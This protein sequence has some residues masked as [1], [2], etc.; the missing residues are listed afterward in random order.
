MVSCPFAWD[1]ATTTGPTGIVG[2]ATTLIHALNDSGWDGG[3]YR[4]GYYDDGAPLGSWEN[5]ECAIDRPGPGLVGAV[6]CGL[7]ESGRAG[8]GRGRG[9]SH[10]RAQ[11]VD[12]SADATLRRY[13]SRPRLHQGLRGRHARERRPV[14]ARGAVGGARHGQARS[15][16]SRRRPAGSVESRVPRVRSG[17]RRAL[18]CGALRGGRRRLRRTA[19]CRPRRLDLVHRF[20]GLDDAGG[21]G[22]GPGSAGA[23]RDRGAGALRARRLARVQSQLACARSRRDP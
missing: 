5:K 14:H 11:P 7:A 12:P 8:D 23:G 3:W 17:P 20:L 19:P 4:R 2:I 13:A 18:S 21:P 9:A 22:I 10:R 1:V 6:G 15:S 16:R